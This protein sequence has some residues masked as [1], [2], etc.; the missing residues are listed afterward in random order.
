MVDGGEHFLIRRR[1]DISDQL[2][3]VVLHASC[4]AKLP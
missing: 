2:R 3:D 4:E 1:G